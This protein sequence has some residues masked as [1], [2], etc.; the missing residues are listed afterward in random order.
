MIIGFQTAVGYSEL[1]NIL[2]YIG[3]LY[4]FNNFSKYLKIFLDVAINFL[5]T[6][7]P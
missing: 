3:S 5:K 7:I 6:A 4:C 2:N 1:H